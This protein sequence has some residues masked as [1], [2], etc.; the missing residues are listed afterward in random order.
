MPE[1]QLNGPLPSR[2]VP[3]GRSYSSILF[4]PSTSL[5]VAA[6]S[7]RAQFASFDEDGNKIWEPDGM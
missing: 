4:E 3:R 5:I 6:S 7:L 1:F 2:S